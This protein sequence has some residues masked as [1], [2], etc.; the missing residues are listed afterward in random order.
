MGPYLVAGLSFGACVALEIALQLPAV[1]ELLLLNGS[2]TY[3]TIHAKQYRTNFNESEN[4]EVAMVKI[5]V[6]TIKFFFSFSFS[7]MLSCNSWSP[8][9]IEQ[10]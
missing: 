2:Q 5:F 10:R 9:S 8:P 1:A 4:A 6:M 3:F 7:S